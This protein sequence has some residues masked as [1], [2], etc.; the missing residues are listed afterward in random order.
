LPHVLVA[1]AAGLEAFHAG[2]QPAG[3]TEGGVVHRVL[4]AYLCHDRRGV[5]LDCLVV[6]GHLRQGFFVLLTESPE[7]I[8]VRLLPRT[9]PQKTAGVKRLLVWIASRLRAGTPGAEFGRTNLAA[10]MQTPLP[11]PD[12]L[13]GS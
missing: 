1:G 8:M 3:F 7:G 6:E 9:S 13:L 11:G 4:A 5:L 12:D 10:Q 2:F